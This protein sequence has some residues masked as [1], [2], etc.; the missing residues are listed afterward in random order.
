MGYGAHTNSQATASGCIVTKNT[1]V[2]TSG[3]TAGAFGRIYTGC[4]GYVDGCTFEDNTIIALSGI[5][6]G[7]VAAWS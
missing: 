4:A 1:L 6:A 5:S 3:Y 7:V 2:S